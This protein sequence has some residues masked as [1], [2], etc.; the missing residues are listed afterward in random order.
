MSDAEDRIDDYLDGLLDLE[1]PDEDDEPYIKPFCAERYG[2]TILEK[3]QV[4]VPADAFDPDDPEYQNKMDDWAITVAWEST[5]DWRIPAEWWV[6]RWDGDDAIVVRAAN[7]SPE[8]I[9]W[10]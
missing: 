5:P 3:F 8:E 4:N 1:G 7:A 9:A 10:E 2:T 6:E